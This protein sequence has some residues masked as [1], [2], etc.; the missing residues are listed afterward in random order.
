MKKVIIFI[1]VFG[2]VRGIYGQYD[3]GA[4]NYGITAIKP[5]ASQQGIGAGIRVEYAPNCYTT[6]M[7]ELAQVFSLDT[8][9]EPSGGYHEFGIGVNLILF[10]WYP[11]TITGGIGYIGNNSSF[12][13]SVEDDAFLAFRTGDINHGAQIKIRA[14]YH[15]STPIHVFAE[16]NLKSLG[17]EYDTVLLGISYDFNTR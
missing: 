11:T 10:N 6:Y 5:V 17:R 1:F 9:Q 8:E 13:P 3:P 15:L 12:F 4:V 2:F 14:L 7:G 16:F